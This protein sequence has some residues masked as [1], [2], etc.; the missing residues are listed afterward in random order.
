MS[1]R[2]E[3]YVGTAL[4]P[5]ETRKLCLGRGSYIGD[6]TAPG[7]LHAAFVRSTHAHA[8]IRRLDIAAARRASWRC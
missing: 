7:L 3:G 6:L 8:R 2:H 4:S 1:E 5:R